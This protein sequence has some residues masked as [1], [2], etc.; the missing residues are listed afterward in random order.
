MSRVVD[1]PGFRIRYDGEP[2]YLRA[3]VYDGTD[4][5]QVSMAIWR[6]LG[7]ECRAVGVTRLLVLEEL[8]S[9]VDVADVPRVIQAMVDAGMTTVR[10]AFVELL[11]D[12]QGSEHGEILCLEHGIIVRSFSDEDSARRWLMYGD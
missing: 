4:S 1:G 3:H 6:M 7:E 2:G 5:L 9:T 11:D 12:I 8:H 10:I